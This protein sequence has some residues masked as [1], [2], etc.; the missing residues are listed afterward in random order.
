MEKT[1]REKENNKKLVPDKFSRAFQASALPDMQNVQTIVGESGIWLYDCNCVP[2]ARTDDL[3]NPVFRL[4]HDSVGGE[5]YTWH[6]HQYDAPA[7]RNNEEAEIV[8]KKRRKRIKKQEPISDIRKSRNSRSSGPGGC[9]QCMTVSHRSSMNEL[10]RVISWKLMRTQPKISSPIKIHNQIK[11]QHCIIES[12][13]GYG[14]LALEPLFSDT[15][16]VSHLTNKP[17]VVGPDYSTVKS[18]YDNPIVHYLNNTGADGQQI[19]IRKTPK[20]DTVNGYAWLFEQGTHQ[21]SI[22]ELI[23]KPAMTEKQKSM[24]AAYSV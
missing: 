8:L 14:L 11:D 3:A 18:K 5:H 23:S 24:L 12:S 21:C 9:D 10:L 7:T 13:S 19:Y 2:A 1:K 15:S 16:F 6:L 20:N 4:F 22:G 17:S